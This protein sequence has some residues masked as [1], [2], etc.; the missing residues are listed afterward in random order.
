M[1]TYH[2]MR[3]CLKEALQAALNDICSTTDMCTNPQNL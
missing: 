2:T 1:A 3:A